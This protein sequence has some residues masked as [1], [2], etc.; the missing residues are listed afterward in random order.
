MS[1]EVVLATVLVLS[2]P[3]GASGQVHEGGNCIRSL[4]QSMAG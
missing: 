3:L 1:V 4:A 2:P